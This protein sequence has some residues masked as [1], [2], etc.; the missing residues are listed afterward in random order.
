MND[1]ITFEELYNHYKATKEEE[2]A[3]RREIRNRDYDALFKRYLVS[4]LCV[5]NMHE[6]YWRKEK[7]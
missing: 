7:K 6:N 1:N 4:V 3:I 5:R 2:K